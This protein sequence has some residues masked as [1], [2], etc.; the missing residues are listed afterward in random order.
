MPR[1]YLSNQLAYSDHINSSANPALIPPLV[2]V[3]FDD[4]LSIRE[5]VTARVVSTE[6]SQ[7]VKYST[8]RRC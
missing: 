8:K 1:L 6:I 2:P 7:D 4:V 5:M 3:E